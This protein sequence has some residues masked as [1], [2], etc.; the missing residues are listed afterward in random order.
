M[1]A[2]LFLMFSV[3]A[4]LLAREEYGTA[5]GWLTC[6]SSAVVCS[7]LYRLTILLE[8]NKIPDR[9]IRKWHKQI[10]ADAES[11]LGRP[12]T[13][14]EKQLIT[15]R[16]GCIALERIHD[17]I[18]GGTKE[19]IISYLNSESGTSPNQPSEGTR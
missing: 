10:V 5:T 3:G 4:G 16:G 12:L 6:I 17:N 19:D 14:T 15:S 13:S 1:L 9:S 11:K 2:G 18:K 8:E 7:G